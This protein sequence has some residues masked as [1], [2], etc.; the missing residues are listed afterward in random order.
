MKE[1]PVDDDIIKNEI[2]AVK[3]PGVYPIKRTYIKFAKQMTYKEKYITIDKA[4]SKSF[5]QF[6]QMN[7]E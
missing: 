6:V 3:L 2:P 5:Y 4:T 7:C 1:V